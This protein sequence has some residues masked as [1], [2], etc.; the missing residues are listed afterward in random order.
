MSNPTQ[1][2]AI[3]G[4]VTNNAGGQ[5]YDI[6]PEQK[7][8]RFLIL[9]SDK[10]QYYVT[11]AENT[12]EHLD[13]ILK[14][15]ESGKGLDIVKTLVDV[16]V[17]ARAP[18]QI[19]T[20]IVLAICSLSPDL[21]LKKYANEAVSKICRIPTHLFEYLD[22]R[23]NI[24][25][26][27]N[28]TTGWGKAHRR[29]ISNWYNSFRGGSEIDL[30]RTTTKYASRHDYTHRDV[31][32]LCHS[33]PNSLP[34]KI[35]Y[36][37]LT[38]GIEGALKVS[39][40]QLSE[41]SPSYEI[42]M[43]SNVIQHIDAVEEAK[44]LEIKDEIKMCELI[45]N[46]N[47]VREHIPS[48]LLNSKM[49]WIELLKNMPLTALIRSLSKISTIGITESSEQVQM[50]IDKLTNKDIIEKS[51]I[52][53]L[54]VLVAHTTYSQGKG[55]KGS[56]SW[57]P[58]PLIIEALDKTF[59]L[60]FKNVVPS[61]KRILNAID[62]SGSMCSQC[63]GG[64]GMPITC[65]QASAVMALIMARTEPFCHSV[66]FSVD[67]TPNEDTDNIYPYYAWSGTPIMKELP[68]RKETTIKEAYE[69][70]QDS[71][72]GATDCAMPMEYARKNKLE[73]DTFIVYTDSETYY[74]DIHPSEALK[75]YREEMKIPNAK[76]IVMGMQS[77]G[78]TIAD[79]TDKGMMDVVGFDSAAP[80][81][82]SDFSAGRL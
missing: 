54:Q 21:E 58:N 13:N 5:S 10:P 66:S 43:A 34:R 48:C 26:K 51:K 82:V 35:I 53:P 46:N 12:L 76:L 42:E 7:L 45:H 40:D 80:Q 18:K 11:A 41:Q 37:Y 2:E 60:S 55:Q 70:T 31:L 62:V 38:K 3:D 6:S 79:P 72:F 78:F 74:G 4:T 52:H 29:V 19:Y 65:H 47:L 27:I 49:V 68:L 44:G 64:S 23:E 15:V 9:G 20:F 57:T 28:K 8:M 63:N 73:I 59:E 39:A 50:I 32:R 14:M 30:I 17:A 22:I 1:M 67:T 75:K 81:I 33:K 25:L 16:S 36:V 61:S 56:L 71:H 77:N 24:S 69:I